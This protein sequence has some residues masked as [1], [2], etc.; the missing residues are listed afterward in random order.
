MKVQREKLQGNDVLQGRGIEWPETEPWPEPVDGAALLTDLSFLVGR[1]VS[2]P[3]RAAGAVAL[4]SIATWLHEHLEVSAFLNVTSA[5]KR[6]GKSL[7]FEVI[8]E[9]THRPLPLSGS[10][11]PAAL[12]RIV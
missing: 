10:I 7:L 3:A 6:C 5:T 8:A 2:M 12:F 11:S 1:Y 4:W 9:L